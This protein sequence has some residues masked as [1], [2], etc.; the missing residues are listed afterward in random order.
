[1]RTQEFLSCANRAGKRRSNSHGPRLESLVDIPI[2][3]LGS[4]LLL[5]IMRSCI[6]VSYV[7]QGM[8]SRIQTIHVS[9]SRLMCSEFIHSRCIAWRK[10][11]LLLSVLERVCW[12]HRWSSLWSFTGRTDGVSSLVVQEQRRIVGHSKRSLH[13]NSYWFAPSLA[14]VASIP[15][16][17]FNWR[18]ACVLQVPLMLFRVHSNKRINICLCLQIT[19]LAGPRRT[20]ITPPTCLTQSIDSYRRV[21]SLRVVKFC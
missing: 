1:M 15:L 6:G 20:Q 10:R 16:E 3:V 21:N 4:Q 13:P 2:I 19:T 18:P 8:S 5:S 12:L 11:L 9:G 17:I 14:W 7:H